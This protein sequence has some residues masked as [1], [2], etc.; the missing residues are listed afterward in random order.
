MPSGLKTPEEAYE[1]YA[2]PIVGMLVLDRYWPDR[3]PMSLED[4][5]QYR[6]RLL[7]EIPPDRLIPKRQ[8]N[9]FFAFGDLRHAKSQSRGSPAHLQPQHPLLRSQVH[10]T[11]PRGATPKAAGSFHRFYPLAAPQSLRMMG[12]H[13]HAGHDLSIKISAPMGRI[14]P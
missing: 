14:I 3:P 7:K 11:Q 12:L 6:D 2:D 9:E 10:A 4:A 13:A 5:R 1:S 8:P